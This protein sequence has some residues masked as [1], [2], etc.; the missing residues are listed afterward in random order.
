[1][2]WHG[3]IQNY[4]KPYKCGILSVSFM[5]HVLSWGIEY[6]AACAQAATKT[7]HQ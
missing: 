5:L 4:T 7:C 2:A 1:M 6:I 3:N